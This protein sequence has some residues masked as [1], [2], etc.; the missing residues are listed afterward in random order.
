MYQKRSLVR[1]YQSF[2]VIKEL[3][4]S[5][6]DVPW[7]C[8]GKGRALVNVVCQRERTWKCHP[9]FISPLSK[10]YTKLQLGWRK[11]GGAVTQ[12]ACMVVGR[13]FCK[14]FTI[15]ESLTP[16]PITIKSGFI[17]Y[18]HDL[19]WRIF[20]AFNRLTIIKLRFPKR[21]QDRKLAD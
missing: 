16:K 14:N 19:T 15:K 11:G 5:K 10:T 6:N 20:A 7:L 8:C 17:W 4:D 1:L 3:R 21:E 12:C 2:S 13:V 18:V 9:M